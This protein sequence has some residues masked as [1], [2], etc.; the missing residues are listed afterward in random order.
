MSLL[1]LASSEHFDCT[2]LVI[3]VERTADAE[4]VKDVNRS[5]AWVGFELTMLEAWAG[6]GGCISERYVFLGMEI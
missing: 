5:L 1:E 4:E 6:E 2:D 3:G